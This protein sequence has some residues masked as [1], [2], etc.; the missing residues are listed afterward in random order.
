M[1][2]FGNPLVIGTAAKWMELS[3]EPYPAGMPSGTV[4]SIGEGTEER[5]YKITDV[6]SFGD[7]PA[8]VKAKTLDLYAG[9]NVSAE[10]L[11][12]AAY[13][14]QTDVTIKIWKW[15]NE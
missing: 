6:G 3:D 5:F 1:K 15:G 12:S 10:A 2:P 11:T 4:F 8:D 9:D 13:G 7:Q 14:V